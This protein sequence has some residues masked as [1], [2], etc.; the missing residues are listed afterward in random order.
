MITDRVSS[1]RPGRATVANLFEHGESARLS[2]AW[3][4]RTRR[5]VPRGGDPG[6]RG[7]WL[8]DFRR[9]TLAAHRQS[10][11][12]S[13]L[14]RW[15]CRVTAFLAG[16]ALFRGDARIRRKH[17][18]G[19]GCAAL[20]SNPR[21]LPRHRQPAVQSQPKSLRACW[22]WGGLTL[23]F[24]FTQSKTVSAVRLQE[25]SIPSRMASL[26]TA[27]SDP[28]KWSA[29]VDGSGGAEYRAKSNLRTIPWSPCGL[30]PE[31]R[32]AAM[33]FATERAIRFDETL[34]T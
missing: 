19:F 6:P 28:E 17:C 18:V 12:P 3:I 30:R 22:R 24:A 21:R 33:R 25:A 9:I 20:D 13:G 4:G 15:G 31:E 27:D 29:A 32:L 23:R 14:S 8:D 2:S 10:L 5:L 34:L 16:L 11:L 26:A 1:I 7:N